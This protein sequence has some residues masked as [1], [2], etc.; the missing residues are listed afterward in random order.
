MLADDGC[1]DPWY[2][3]N[4]LSLSRQCGSIVSDWCV[5]QN[6]R[7]Y[8][9]T[10]FTSKYK[11]TVLDCPLAEAGGRWTSTSPVLHIAPPPSAE[12]CM[13]TCGSFIPIRIEVQRAIDMGSV[14]CLLCVL[15]TGQRVVYKYSSCSAC[16]CVCVCVCS[17]QVTVRLSSHFN[18]SDPIRN[19]I[20]VVRR[21]NWEH[22][23]YTQLMRYYLYY[24][25]LL[26]PV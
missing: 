7:K 24:Y 17:V 23:D 20:F 11:C 13:F 19:K 16:V 5:H 18:R 21:L 4:H 22:S 12:Q 6:A 9:M 1:T 3:H 25:M 10:P 8:H 14:T 15:L 26:L 2:L